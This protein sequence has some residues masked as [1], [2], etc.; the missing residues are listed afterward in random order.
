MPI[1]TAAPLP[2]CA[3]CKD[4]AVPRKSNPPAIIFTIERDGFDEG[5]R[6]YLCRKCYFAGPTFNMIWAKLREQGTP[7]LAYVR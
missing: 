1:K 3:Y 6:V 4:P 2:V 7:E 5:P